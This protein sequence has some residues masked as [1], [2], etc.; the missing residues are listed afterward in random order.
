MERGNNKKITHVT[1]DQFLMF[2]CKADNILKSSFININTFA[3]MRTWEIQC[4]LKTFMQ[5][6][7]AKGCMKIFTWDWI[8]GV[9]TTY[10]VK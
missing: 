5:P 9:H 8:S 10:I 7:T 1:I 2:F 6:L 3:L 4:G